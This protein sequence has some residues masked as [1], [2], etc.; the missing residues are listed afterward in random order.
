MPRRRI[1]L[2]AVPGTIDALH[3]PGSLRQPGMDVSARASAHQMVAAVESH[4]ADLEIVVLPGPGRLS[5]ELTGHDWLTVAR[6]VEEALSHRLDGI[7][8][9]HG[10]NNLEEIAY[11]LALTLRFDEPVVVTGAML[12]W[13]AP[14]TDGPF[15]LIQALRVAASE[16][17]RG[18]GVLIA[19]GREVF[20]PRTATKISTIALSAFGAPGAGPLGRLDAN[21]A[22]RY[23]EPVLRPALPD[24]DLATLG[25][26]PRVD[27]IASHSGAD[28][29]LIE[30]SVSAGAAGLVTAAGGGGV[31]TGA[32]LQ[33]LKAAA[34]QGVV[35]CQASRVPGGLVQLT[36]ERLAHGFVAAGTLSPWKARILLMLALTHTR[37]VE[38]VR[39]LF[40]RC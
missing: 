13:N 33:A 16:S 6:A 2:L 34:A 37:D 38:R 1:G 14:G 9:T 25:S 29:A 30:A 11:F 10:T 17:S 20:G 39:D 27:V 35:V 28:G 4:L 18:R 40:A 32:E 36:R 12:P 26:L 24:I 7:V 23:H 22:V 8:V 19:F 5:H 21:E 15:N 3:V 31:T